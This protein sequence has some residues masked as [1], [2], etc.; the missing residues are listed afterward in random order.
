MI[1]HELNL[2]Q[3]FAVRLTGGQPH[4]GSGGVELICF[5]CAAIRGLTSVADKVIVLREVISEDFE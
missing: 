1:S 2:P 4:I 5:H 3:A